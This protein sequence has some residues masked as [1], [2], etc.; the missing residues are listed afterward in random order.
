M[1]RE[2]ARLSPLRFHG[3]KSSSS[4]TSTV[5]HLQTIPTLL[6]IVD[7]ATGQYLYALDNPLY[8]R[9]GKLQTVLYRPHHRGDDDNHTAAVYP[10]LT[11]TPS[12]VE[13]GQPLTV[14]WSLPSSSLLD[15]DR[16]RDQDQGGTTRSDSNSKANSTTTTASDAFFDITDD[17]ILVF[18][19]DPLGQ[20]HDGEKSKNDE[21]SS[22]TTSPLSSPVI[23]DIATIEQARSTSLKQSPSSSSSEPSLLNRWQIPHLPVLRYGS[24]WFQLYNIV[25]GSENAS[26]E[27]DS[28]NNS[29]VSWGLLAQSNAFV[30]IHRPTAIHL[31]LTGDATEMLVSFTTPAIMDDDDDKRKVGTSKGFVPIAILVD[32]QDRDGRVFE[33]KTD[34]YAAQDLCQAPAN[35]TGPGQF[36]DPG[37]LHAVK[38][39]GLV[40]NHPYRYRVAIKNGQGIVMSSPVYSFWSPLARGDPQPYSY[41]VYGD[42]GCPSVGWGEGGLWT[43]GM[44]A[45]EVDRRGNL[46]AFARVT[47]AA[48]VPSDQSSL[49][50]RAVHHFGD[51]SY[52]R[53]AAHIWDAWFEM[54]QVFSGRVPLMVGVG[55]HEYDH[56]SGGENGK[57]PSGVATSHGF[58]P[59]WGNF[60]DDSGGECGVPTAKRFTM[61]SSSTEEGGSGSNGVFWYSFDFGSVHTVVISSEHDLGQGSP[62]HKWLARDLAMVNRT[63]TPWLIVETHRPLYEGEASWDQNAVGIGMRYEME[64]LLHSYKVDLVLA[65]HYHAYHRT[66]D[67]LYRSRCNNGGPMHITVGSAGAHLDDTFV[68]ANGW[69]KKVIMGEYGYGRITIRDATALHF[70]FVKAGDAN[71]TTAG[72]VH[73]DVWIIRRR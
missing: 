50:V 29:L 62:Q 59:S 35:Q 17:S 1:V 4:S 40:P 68:Y 64:D 30:P 48:T 67:G 31:A 56:T 27:N 54:I 20:H 72:Q 9:L 8:R 47:S 26:N 11:V 69:T 46:S 21:G 33:G 23:L 38:L 51:L 63:V 28:D 13:Y 3:T 70:E 43:A 6:S 44:A 49:P 18:V 22:S 19:C 57:D 53:G 36:Q 39:E 71:D 52:A 14:S 60:G 25:E 34:T 45:R 15:L 5:V 65:G 16:N 37:W 41:L 24:C 55:N 42:Q 10:T 66:C 73:D 32:D 7:P 61:P 58:M 2:V 12:W